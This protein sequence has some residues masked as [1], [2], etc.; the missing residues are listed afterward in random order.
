MV[1]GSLDYMLGRCLARHHKV[2]LM[3]CN[4]GVSMDG[5]ECV[6]MGECGLACCEKKLF[7]FFF[8]RSARK[9]C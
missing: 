9:K 7:F 6:L 8:F 2:F 4:E 5:T 3:L 1:P